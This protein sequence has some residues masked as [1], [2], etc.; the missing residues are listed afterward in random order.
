MRIH[1]AR[2]LA[3]VG[4]A[5]LVLSGVTASARAGDTGPSIA[6]QVGSVTWCRQTNGLMRQVWTQACKPGESKYQLQSGAG[7]AG[8]RGAQGAAGPRGATGAPGPQGAT[9]ATGAVG[10]TGATGT[11]GATGPQGP[12]DLY[13]GTRAPLGVVGDT[14]STFD[15]A[16]VPAG[17]YLVQFSAFVFNSSA[18]Q[19]ITCAVLPSSG[20]SLHLPVVHARI[21]VSPFAEAPISASGWYVAAAGT[22]FALACAVSGTGQT[23]TLG[24][25]SM[26]ALKVA[27]IH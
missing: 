22:T 5:T 19:N 21:T 15:T 10:A 24:D 13:P 7:P 18:D 2:T 3:I 9:G 16:A 6:K 1:T 27:T 25:L 23:A 17:S 14:V 20:P 11:T 26:S 8:P 12:S 4:T